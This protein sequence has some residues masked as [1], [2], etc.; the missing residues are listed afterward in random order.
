MKA[1]DEDV[2]TI[3]CPTCNLPIKDEVA[4]ECGVCVDD[5]IEKCA[6]CLDKVGASSA[7]EVAELE[8][9]H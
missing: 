7:R 5:H 6:I 4:L 9:S 8:C 3:G 2:E 1:K